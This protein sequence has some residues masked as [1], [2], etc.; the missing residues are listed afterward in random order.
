[1]STCLREIVMASERHGPVVIGMDGT[2][3]AIRAATYG[4]WEAKRRRVPLRLVFAH[5]PTPMWGLSVLIADDY[6]WEEDWVRSVLGEAEKQI[7]A[8]HPDVTVQSAVISA[9]PAAC[10]VEESKHASLVVI[11]TRATG[12]VVGRLTGSVAAQVAA[13][14]HTA[15]V[16]LRPTNLGDPDPATFASKPV[17]VGLDGSAESEQA[18][19]FAIEQAVARGAD[20]HAVYVWSVLEVHDIGPIIADRFVNS[21]EEAK[22]LRLLTEATEG[23]TERYPDLRITRRVIHDLD[24]ADALAR[25]SDGAGLLVVG[26]RGHGGFLGLRLGS[27]VDALIRHAGAPVAVIRGDHHH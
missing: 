14:A 26:S 10:L 17:I 13:H 25:A 20:L 3:E 24:P 16:V 12:G 1:M 6:R 15:V 21:D 18:M 19:A 23:W 9:S 22:A 4:A 2:D 7:A 8:A 11:G 27:T 5:Q